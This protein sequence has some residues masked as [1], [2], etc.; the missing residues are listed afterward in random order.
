MEAVPLSGYLLDTSVIIDWLRG[1]PSTVGWLRVQLERGSD[2]I[3]SPITVAEVMA[4]TGPS[5]RPEQRRRLAAFPTTPIDFEAAALAGEMMFDLRS[6]G[7]PT[8]MADRLVAAQA[9]ILGLTVATSNPSHFPDV[10]VE[11]PRRH[12]A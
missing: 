2:L 10:A 5:A 1:H 3:L 7:K 4:G 6:Q 12:P 9:R 11:D 8:G